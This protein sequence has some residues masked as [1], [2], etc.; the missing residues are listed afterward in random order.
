V[1]RKNIVK[2]CIDL[3]EEIAEKKDDFAKFYETFG[4]NLKYGIHEDST[5]RKKLS[6]LLRFHSTKSTDEMTSF[7][8]YVTRMK[9]GQK[10]IYFIS[11]ENRKS[12]ENSPFI[13]A[14][15]KKGFEVLYMTEPIDEY[16][17]QQ[18]KEFDGKKLVNVTKEGLKLEETDEEKKKHEEEKN[19]NENLL[20][21]VKDIL[22]DKVEKVVLSDR[23]VNSPCILVTG[24]YGWSANMERIMKAQALRDNSMQTYMVSKKTLELNADHPIIAEL[25]KKADADKSDKTV[26]DLVWLVFETALLSSGFSLE[27]PHAFASRIHR[28]IK[29]GLSIDDNEEESVEADLPA[30]EDAGD[31][32][33][34]MEEVD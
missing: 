1:I 4:K 27:E 28:M 31:E 12:V 13:E 29:L 34:K 6:E 14:L 8:D 33:S 2:K 15:K 3:F 11:G 7:K 9:E 32:G 16:M 21:V 18:L 24:E 17:V 26:K 19:A 25:R 23:L 20:K 22:G 10:D 5:N 30:L